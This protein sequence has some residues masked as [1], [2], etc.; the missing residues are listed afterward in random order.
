MRAIERAVHRR[1]LDGLVAGGYPQIRTAHIALL[2]HMTT[3]GRRAS[4][5]AAL[6]QVT[7][8]AVSQLV[9]Y[10][11]QHGLVERVPDRRDGR[12]ALIRA[13][14]AAERGFRISRDQLARAEDQWEQMIGPGEL[15]R[16]AELLRELERWAAGH[17]G[18]DLPEAP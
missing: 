10:L 1:M 12:A 7:K 3:E 15:A 16:L 5:F 17:V 18:R 8:A 6:M 9:A 14:T 11:E 2:A 4:E 13:T